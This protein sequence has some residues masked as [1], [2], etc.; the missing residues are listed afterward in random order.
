MAFSNTVCWTLIWRLSTKPRNTSR[1]PNIQLKKTQFSETLWGGP[2]SPHCCCWQ[3][4]GLAGGWLLGPPCTP[5]S[6]WKYPCKSIHLVHPGKDPWSQSH[7]RRKVLLAATVC[8]L[9][10]CVVWNKKIDFAS[11]VRACRRA[12]RRAGGRGCMCV[13]VCVGVCVCVQQCVCE[14]VC[15]CVFC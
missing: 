6:V 9:S 12:G 2:P 15:V 7:H 8:L 11:H 5:D 14:Q 1:N 3:A 13:C 4:G 10:T